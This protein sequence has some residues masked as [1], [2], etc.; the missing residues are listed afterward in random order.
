[1]VG[2]KVAELE[3]TL[4]ELTQSSQLE[5]EK[6]SQQVDNKSRAGGLHYN[7]TLTTRGSGGSRGGSWGSM[8]PPFQSC[9]TQDS[10]PN[11]AV[12]GAKTAIMHDDS[13]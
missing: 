5:V 1:M 7:T 10:L 8:E 3:Q 4:T 12:R 13:D 11:Y 2:E 9:Q 6:L